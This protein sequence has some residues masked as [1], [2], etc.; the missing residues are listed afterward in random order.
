MAEASLSLPEPNTS[1]AESRRGVHKEPQGASRRS[2]ES[3]NSDRKEPQEPST[4][5]IEGGNSESEQGPNTISAESG[6]GVHK[7]PQEA[8]RP[9]AESESSVPQEPTQQNVSSIESGSSGHKETQEPNTSSAESGNGGHRTPIEHLGNTTRI[10]VRP[11]TEHPT[12]FGL[13]S[14]E[15][16]VF[17][18]TLRFLSL[19]RPTRACFA[20][21][22]FYPALVNLLLLLIITSDFYML[23]KG[24]G[25]S[26]D[27][28]VFLAID[29]GMYLSHLFGLLY[30]RSRD[31]ES[32]LLG[33]G[34][35]DRLATKLR[36]RLKRLK[37]GVLFSYMLLVVLVLLFFNT[38]AWLK[39][40]FQCNSSFKF[41]HGFASHFVCFLNYPTNVYGVGNSL[42]LSWTMC[43]LQQIC[44]VRLK[45]LHKNYLTWTGTAEEAICHHLENYSRKVKKSCGELKI[46]FVAHNLILIIATPFLC[47]DIIDGF[48]AIAIRK[49]NRVHAGLSVGFL[50]YTIVI[51][52][53]PLYFAEQLQNHDENLCTRV[54]EF[55]PRRSQEAES[56]PYTFNSRSEVNKFLSYLKNRK[57]G[58]LMGSYSFQLKLSMLSVFLAIFAFATRTVG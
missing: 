53:A 47:T 12:H 33:I 11:G 10:A 31:L 18:W 28:Y 9:S 7:E 35:N 1:S 36:T 41:L 48:K 58:F 21:R 25:K 52:V 27:I 40:R 34:L 30:F 39:G 50:V 14:Q 20:E 24:A 19:W 2:T 42:A 17:R 55:C 51:W 8:S 46:W 56:G 22:F 37:L 29:G 38:T 13:L 23:A 3:E 4:S 45:Q 32:N 15:L 43:L 49:S 6:R 26:L 57:S 16:F 54:N 44:C 5:S